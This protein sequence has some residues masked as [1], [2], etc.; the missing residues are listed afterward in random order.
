MVVDTSALFA[1]LVGEDERDQF[2]DL[3]LRSPTA[4]ISVVSVVETTIALI[5]K[6]LNIQ[7]SDVDGVL[8]TLGIAVR[9]VD[10]NQGLLAR[11]AFLQYGRGRHPARLNFGDCF[12]YA[13]A[14]ARGDTL[15]FKGEDFSKTDLIPARQP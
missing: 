3:I 4:V 11:Q 1:I 2:E 12:P 14:K 5:R 10:V 7:A 9:P 8:S 13:L 6:Q 15:L